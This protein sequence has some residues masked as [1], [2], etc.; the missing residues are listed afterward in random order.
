MTKIH[1]TNINIAGKGGVNNFGSKI[2]VQVGNPNNFNNFDC[3]IDMQIVGGNKSQE[4]KDY[5]Q[6]CKEILDMLEK[7]FKK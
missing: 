2:D 3:D 5:D 7:K 6:R 4:E 1:I